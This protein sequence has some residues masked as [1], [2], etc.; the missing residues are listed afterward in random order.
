M[1]LGTFALIVMLATAVRAA[2]QDEADLRQA[3]A[4]ERTMERIIEQNEAAIASILVSRSDL[5]Q[6]FGQGPDKDRPGKLGIFDPIALKNNRRFKDETAEKQL[7]WPKL[8]DFTHPAFVPKSF[9]S[10]VVIDADGYILTNFH[11][12]QDATKIFIRL[13]GGK[14]G[15][16]DIHAAD[17]RSDLAVLKLLNPTALPLKTITLG[18]ADKLKRGHFVLTMSNPYAV[19]FRDGQPSASYGILSNINRRA[20][21]NLKEDERVKPLHFYATLLQTDTRLNLGCSGGAL[22]NLSG[23]LVGL[24]TSTAAIQGGE[25]PGG[26]AIPINTPMRR[27]VEGLKRGEEIDYGFLGVGFDERTNNGKIGVRLTAVGS[28]SPAHL[29]GELRIG[30][31]I[32]AVNGE[33]VQESDDIFAR[34]GIHLAGSK[35]KLHVRREKTPDR[36]VEVTLAKLYVPGKAIASSTGSRPFFRGLRADYSSLVAQQPPRRSTIPKGVLISEL[37]P[38]TSADRAK[39]RVGDV[40]THVDGLAITTPTAFYQAVSAARDRAV[41]LTISGDPPMRVLLKK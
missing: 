23:E 15:Y 29:D 34:V 21:W 35:V 10:G 30:D 22:L 2:A 18:D 26:F 31:V 16:A 17:P 27:I 20:P 28:G 14:S 38:D 9:G 33:P 32:L 8:M 13:P 36:I 4:L 1:R 6:E 5:Y 39:L 19:G 3:R 37:Q 7:H 41:E 25:S 12:V 11:V 40:V 24:L